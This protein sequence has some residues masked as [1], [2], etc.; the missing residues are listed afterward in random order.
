MNQTTNLEHALA[1]ST[2]LPN[3]YQ[4]QGWTA[5]PN[6]RGTIDIIWNCLLTLFLSCWSVLV[7][8]VPKP[9]SASWRLL[10]QKFV[11][12]GLC[13][14]APEIV[15]QS[16]LAQ[17][18]SARRSVRLFHE[19]GYKDW[20]L[21]H[22]FYADMG[23]FHLRP[24]DWK[25]FPI[26]A[27]QL[28]YLVIRGY[29]SYP[30]LSD[31]Q[32]RDKNK[33][34]GM[35]R[36]ITLAQTTWFLLTFI[37]R[38]SQGLAV[39]ALELSTSAFV[40]FSLAT[41]LCW[42]K[43]PADVQSPEY[44]ETTTKLTEIL[45]NGGED[46]RRVYYYTPLDFVSRKEWYWSKIWSNGLNMLRKMRILVPSTNPPIT[47]F[48]NTVIPAIDRLPYGVFVVLSLGYFAIFIAGW[49]LEFPTEVERT[50]W[51]A[52]SLT[53]LASCLAECIAL[54]I[55]CT[56]LPLLKDSLP[57]GERLKKGQ[58]TSPPEAKA[59]TK[60]SRL[61]AILNLLAFRMVNNSLLQDPELDTPLGLVI[62]TWL[63]GVFYSSSRAYIFVA[64][65]MEIRL[66]PQS[67]YQDVNW[68]GLWP[69]L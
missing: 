21:R 59:R 23:G 54:Q 24:P 35:L 50:L 36:L 18:L 25:T 53:A 60:A 26:D 51:R 14:L 13:A 55:F 42:M 65:F 34:D 64:D 2:T 48:P 28:H 57:P 1:N 8:N 4:K 41:T 38:A 15:F 19:S 27:K 16:A 31:T 47:H 52:A 63:C 33:I 10:W 39:T 7:V 32:I 69:H 29:L 37:L 46:A 40:S 45:E 56:W 43:K 17:W 66:L 61:P 12:V 67:A 3:A 44:L 5:P 62:S 68:S 9:E 49:N 58:D 11:L 22:G 6:G 30:N 20:T